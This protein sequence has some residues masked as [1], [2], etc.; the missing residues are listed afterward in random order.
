MRRLLGVLLLL[1]LVSGVSAQSSDLLTTFASRANMRAGGGVDWRIIGTYDAGTPIRLDG[2][3]FEGNWVR[4]IVPDGT[5]GWVLTESLNI[6]QAQAAGLRGIWVEDPFSLPAPAGGPAP[7]SA[8]AS[9]P[10]PPA[11]AP[12]APPVVASGGIA[13]T[14][15][16]GVN[17]RV[18]PNEAVI[19]G[20]RFQEP[21]TVDGKNAAGNWVRVI[22]ADGARGWVAVE[23]V[24]I[25]A[26]QMT[27]LPVVEGG[28]SSPAAQP[29]AASGE[30]ASSAPP[31]PVVNTAPVRGFSYGGHIAHMS[32]PTVQA[33]QRAGMTWVKRQW[34]YF[35]GQPPEA[36]AGY[37]NEA[38][39]N[40]F[41]IVL[42]IVGV[43]SELN[44]PGYADDYVN[45]VAG[46]AALGA[47]AI[48]VWNEPN[49]DREWPSGSISPQNYTNLLRQAYGAIKGANPNTLVISGAPAPT[50]FFGGC[51]GGG[52]DD[53]LFVRGM[54]A[55]GAANYLDCVG[56][57]YN[58]GIVSPD[59]TSGDPR[60]NS[61]HYT[62]Y[63]RSMINTYTGA[64]GSSRPLCF[65]ELGYLTPEGFPPL[66]G[67]FAWAQN[68]TLAQQAAW[69]DRAVAIAAG[70]GRVRLLIVWNVDFTQYGADPMA[71]YAMIR[72]DGSCPAC[73]A[74]GR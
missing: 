29:P 47:D 53:N 65:T 27:T 36:A 49:I 50:G 16:N 34:R 6:T 28:A 70:S 62:R 7:A 71:G 18:N 55:A 54:A 26:Q 9:A 21:I 31:A 46:A 17:M 41:R 40:G 60:G 25:T 2:Q 4:G 38:H 24:I 69:L 48:E 52:C 45:F 11:S 57:H 3:A 56:I 35:R 68:V 42:G 39:A 10:Q 74:L 30:T 67:G 5:V 72:P 33:M 15:A 32:G 63:L 43:P 58:E 37:I 61:G 8:P 14:T 13:T 44:Q 22:T 59:Q 66:P 12:A 64:F 51:H 1:L 19:R 73:D 23:F 20:L